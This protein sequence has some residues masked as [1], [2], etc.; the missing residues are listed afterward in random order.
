VRVADY[1]LSG[2]LAQPAA[3]PKAEKAEK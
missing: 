3:A 1:G 2:I